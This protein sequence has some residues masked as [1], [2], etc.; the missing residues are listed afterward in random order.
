M[1]FLWWDMEEIDDRLCVLCWRARIGVF[2][3]F[4][5]G[6][7]GGVSGLRERASRVVGTESVE[8]AAVDRE[9]VGRGR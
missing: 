9:V 2:G 3:V 4:G 5:G 1:V 8:V 6:E 7:G